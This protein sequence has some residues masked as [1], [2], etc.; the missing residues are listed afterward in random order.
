MPDPHA[1]DD[2]FDVLMRYVRIRDRAVH[3]TVLTA[4]GE[5]ETAAYKGLF[6]LVRTSMR[7]S[8]LA[9]ALNADPSTVSRHVAFLV[10][11][12]L[13]RRE[14]DPADGRA[15]LLVITDLGRD[16]V[17]SMRRMRREAMNAVMTDWTDDDLQTLVSLLNRFVDA[18]ETAIV[19]I[20]TDI[21]K[22]IRTDCVKGQA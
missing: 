3:S 10:K 17:D 11:E 21:R 7:S 2:L 4:D 18:A 19:G 15:T 13:V 12:G 8:E 6:H 5:I 1:I 20:P 16:R 14:A 9:T 22:D